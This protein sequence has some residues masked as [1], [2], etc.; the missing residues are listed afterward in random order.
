VSDGP[1]KTHFPT[2]WLNASRLRWP[3]I[4]IRRQDVCLTKKIV[5]L[6][7]SQILQ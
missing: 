3:Y 5:V 4:L 1:K 2:K 7:R 6:K